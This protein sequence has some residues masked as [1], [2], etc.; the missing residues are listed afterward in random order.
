MPAL[1]VADALRARGAE[2]LFVGAA[3]RDELGLVE[4]AGYEQRFLRVRGLSRR[5]P[6][7]ALAALALALRAVPQARKLLRDWR[8]GAVVGGGGYVAFPVGVA[9]IRT[10]VPLILTEADSE[11]GVAN[12][13]LARWARRVCLALPIAG[14]GEPRYVVTG[15]P[16]PA[17]IESTS[18]SAARRELGFGEDDKALLVFGGSQGARTINEAALGAFVEPLPGLH[19]QVV[20]VCGRRDYPQLKAEFEKAGSPA[21]YRLLEFIEDFAGAVVAADLV[22]GRAGASVFEL[23][24]AG[25]PAVLVPYPYASANHQ[26]RNAAWMAEGGAAVVVNDAELT[27]ERL[28]EEV[29]SLIADRRRL[30]EMST[31]AR[32]LARPDAADRVAEITMTAI[33]SG[34]P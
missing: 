30:T 26:E 31:A 25:K 23:A 5:N 16:V 7:K 17:A 4:R 28:R 18:R 27:A 21:H 8:A 24:A 11:L 10:R 14:R 20:H 1:A 32:A 9:A 33:G 34:S 15:R 22:V 13:A 3:G 19:L 6:L 2:V 29:G 12:R